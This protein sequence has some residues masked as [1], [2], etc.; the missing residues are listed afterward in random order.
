M[1]AMEPA[2]AAALPHAGALPLQPA[3]TRFLWKARLLCLPS[4]V[5]VTLSVPVFLN[6]TAADSSTA[7][8]TQFAAAMAYLSSVLVQFAWSFASPRSYMRRKDIMKLVDINCLMPIAVVI[9]Y[10]HPWPP[11]Q[12][13]S[14]LFEFMLVMLGLTLNEVPVR[15]AVCTILAQVRQPSEWLQWLNS[16]Q[17]F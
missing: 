16:A 5:A 10:T 9:Q 14:P 2:E 17:A 3:E 13:H 7:R 11:D 1:H 15:P 4:I 12:A 8:Y 6:A